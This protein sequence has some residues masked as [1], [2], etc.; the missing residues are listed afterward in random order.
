MATF[1]VNQINDANENIA[2]LQRDIDDR[3]PINLAYSINLQKQWKD[4]VVN[5]NLKLDVF[6]KLEADRTPI[7]I[8][9]L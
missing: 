5:M 2:R 3:S 9:S 7:E 4:S 1:L 8:C 6:R